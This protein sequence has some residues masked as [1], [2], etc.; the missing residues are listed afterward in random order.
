MVFDTPA[1]GGSRMTPDVETKEGV[2]AAVASDPRLSDQE[3]RCG[4]YQELAKRWRG[5]TRDE[6]AARPDCKEFPI[7]EKP[8][9]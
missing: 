8:G 9:A 5:M 6:Y 7:D 3:E 4:V 2:L 1:G